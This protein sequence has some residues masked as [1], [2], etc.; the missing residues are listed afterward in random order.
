MAGMGVALI[1]R[2]TIGL[3]LALG[4]LR[5][6]PVQGFPLVKAWFVAQ[7]RSMP[8]MP[9]HVALRAFLVEHG[10]SVIADL[11]AGYRRAALAAAAV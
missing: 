4:L 1:S 3:E 10:E 11:E 2:H 8:L 6:L 5:V 7:R 9:A